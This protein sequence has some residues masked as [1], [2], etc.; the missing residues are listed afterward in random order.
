MQT[1]APKFA[2]WVVA[3]VIGAAGLLGHFIVIPLAT[4]YSFWF[5]AI[6]FLV[7][8]LATILRGL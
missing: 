4:M 5:V 7:L 8:A 1:N 6:G 2:V 3:V